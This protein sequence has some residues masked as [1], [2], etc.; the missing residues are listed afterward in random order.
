[1][2]DPI[3]TVGRLKL[4]FKASLPFKIS[5][6][7]TGRLFKIHRLLPS[8]DKEAAVVEERAIKS[9]AMAGPLL[10]KLF[11]KPGMPIMLSSF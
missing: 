1:M 9:E 10:S 11:K 2:D 3:K 7:F 8:S 5:S 6:G 4:R